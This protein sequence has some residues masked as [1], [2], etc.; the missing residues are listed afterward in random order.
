MLQ[1]QLDVQ[2]FPVSYAYGLGRVGAMST[3]ARVSQYEVGSSSSIVTA[4]SPAV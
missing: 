1:N 4:T 3:D 2:S